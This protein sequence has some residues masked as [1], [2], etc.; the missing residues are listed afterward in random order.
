MF[1][2]TFTCLFTIHSP[3]GVDFMLSSDKAIKHVHTKYSKGWFG[4]QLDY[5]SFGEPA[6][7]FLPF[8]LCSGCVR[9]AYTGTVSYN[10]SGGNPNNTRSTSS[11]RYVETAPQTL[12]MTFQC[13]QTQTYAGYKYNITNI[14]Y[15]LKSTV[16]YTL[17]KKM[18]HIDTTGAE[19]N[20]FE[21]SIEVM[22]NFI[23][24]NVKEQATRTA[25]SIIRSFHP[26]ASTV[27]TTFSDLDIKINEVYPCFVP[28][29]T[30]KLSY[31]EEEYIVFVSGIDGKVK[32]PHLLNSLYIARTT[33]LISVVMIVIQARNKVLGII[34]GMVTAIM[35]YYAIFF[36]TKCY[37]FLYR[38]F[39]QW[40]QERLRQKYDIADK[41]G[42]CPGPHSR[43]FETDYFNSSYWDTHAYQQRPRNAG[44]S[45]QH[46][47]TSFS[48]TTDYCGGV[49]QSHIC[50]SKG[51]Y[52]CLGLTGNESVN[53]IRSAHR[54]LVLKQHP[55]VGGSMDEMAKVNEAYRVLRNSSLRAAYDKL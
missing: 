4:A 32:G 35:V 52:K 39:Q 10:E 14:H 2:K 50:D 38:N 26:T 22:R 1:R 54:K 33:A 25:E 46:R 30:V 3:R 20:L 12:E 43:R 13:D 48:S 49:E 36:A 31:G 18:N 42:Y 15:T 16:N 55:D 19:I 51:Y 17:M 34:Y 21:Q 41:Q 7:E 37:P 6:K 47:S 23:S 27:S 45:H 29:F 28:C 9:A 53:E 11:S 24:S 8:Y 5:M 40:Q 44:F